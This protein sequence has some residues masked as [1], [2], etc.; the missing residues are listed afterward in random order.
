MLLLL[1]IF[2]AEYD[3]VR[4]E[5][6]L[7]IGN[8]RHLRLQSRWKELQSTHPKTLWFF[9]LE[10]CCYWVGTVALL[11][12]SLNLIPPMVHGAWSMP[13]LRRLT[14]D[15]LLLHLFLF[16]W[17]LSGCTSYYVSSDVY[18]GT[19]LLTWQIMRS[20][21]FEHFTKCL[22]FT[23]IHRL[24]FDGSRNQYIGLLWLVWPVR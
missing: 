6:H 19:L 20:R 9:K 22:L 23:R 1:S 14:Q 2:I 8:L 5:C 3:K 11:Q 13:S 4:A 10:K 12:V 7:W 17:Q 24:G 21:L 16:R 15:E 18:P